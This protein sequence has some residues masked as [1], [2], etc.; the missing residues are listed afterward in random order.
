MDAFHDFVLVTHSQNLIK[1]LFDESE[2]TKRK[3]KMGDGFEM[4]V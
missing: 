3:R 2:L 4:E 1:N